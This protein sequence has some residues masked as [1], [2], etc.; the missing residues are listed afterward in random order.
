M[1]CSSQRLFYFINLVFSLGSKYIT[2]YFTQHSV[3]P[4][5]SIAVSERVKRVKEFFVTVVFAAATLQALQNS[6]LTIDDILDTFSAVADVSA[7]VA[8]MIL[9]DDKSVKID[10]LRMANVLQ[11]KRRAAGDDSAP[12]GSP[13]VDNIVAAAMADDR[14][15]E[16]V[17]KAAESGMSSGEGN[18][19]LVKQ[20][21]VHGVALTVAT[22][23]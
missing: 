6:G 5:F 14:T 12:T 21:L 3:W 20:C 15:E 22:G 18:D 1:D 8:A 17:R 4:S 16:S 2:S 11:V 19:A 7:F 13:F 23:F 9:V 10:L